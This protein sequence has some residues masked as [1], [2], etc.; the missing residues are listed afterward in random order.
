VVTIQSAASARLASQAVAHSTASARRCR[1]GRIS[2]ASP[3]ARCASVTPRTG[4]EVSTYRR[5]LG[6]V[7]LAPAVSPECRCATDDDTSRRP[8]AQSGR[9]FSGGLVAG[10]LLREL[11]A[12]PIAELLLGHREHLVF[13]FLDVMP[14]ELL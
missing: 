10:H 7:D 13:L 4:A 6:Q 11:V 8:V 2:G 1:E 5:R 3:E 9:R 12:P 14:H